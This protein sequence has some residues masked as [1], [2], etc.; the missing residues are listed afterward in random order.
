MYGAVEPL[1]RFVLVPRQQVYTSDFV[2]VQLFRRTAFDVSDPLR[3]ERT[4]AAGGKRSLRS[5]EFLLRLAIEHFL[6]KKSRSRVRV[7]AL[8][9]VGL[10]EECVCVGVIRCKV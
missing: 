10:K 1:H 6:S 8:R 4:P 9:G 7:V 5:V 2:R 3:H